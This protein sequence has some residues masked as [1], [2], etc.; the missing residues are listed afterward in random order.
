MFGLSDSTIETQHDM[1][2]AQ[3]LRNSLYFYCSIGLVL[4]LLLAFAEP[5][6]LLSL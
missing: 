4:N 1:S 3:S 2:K 5:Y 6:N